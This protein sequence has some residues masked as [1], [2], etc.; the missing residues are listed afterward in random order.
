MQTNKEGNEIVSTSESNGGSESMENTNL[1]MFGFHYFDIN[2]VSFLSFSSLMKFKVYNIQSKTFGWGHTLPIHTSKKSK[3]IITAYDIDIMNETNFTLSIIEIKNSSNNNLSII[4]PIIA[5]NVNPFNVR[6]KET[7]LKVINPTETWRTMFL[8]GI[9]SWIWSNSSMYI[10]RVQDN[11]GFYLF[12]EV[13]IGFDIIIDDNYIS[14]ELM[15][16]FGSAMHFRSA[17]EVDDAFE[18]LKNTN[19]S[20]IM[21]NKIYNVY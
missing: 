19:V 1:E 11:L 14:E 7:T 15:K 12:I 21:P 18:S 6:F 10:L 13:S 5:F 2:V 9:I 8:G 4:L 17:A 20:A 16:C 3:R